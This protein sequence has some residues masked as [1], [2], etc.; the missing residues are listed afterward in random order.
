ME[1]LTME[2]FDGASLEIF[3]MADRAG[4][5]IPPL[6]PLTESVAVNPSGGRYAG[7]HGGTDGAGGGHPRHGTPRRD[8]RQDRVRRNFGG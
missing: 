3:A 8:P 2:S 4:R 5:Q 1:K 7:H 6:W